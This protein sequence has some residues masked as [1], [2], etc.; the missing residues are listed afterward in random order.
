MISD[1]VTLIYF[2]RKSLH[3]W[4]T[5][6][7]CTAYYCLFPIWRHS[8]GPSVTPCRVAD[9]RD[10]ISKLPWI[11][12]VHR[13]AGNL[14]WNHWKFGFFK[15]MRFRLGSWFSWEM[16][17]PDLPLFNLWHRF[18]G[19]RW[20]WERRQQ[21]QRNK[22]LQSF[23][24]RSGASKDLHITW[25]YPNPKGIIAFPIP[26]VWSQQRCA[27]DLFLTCFWPWPSHTIPAW[28]R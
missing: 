21:S 4:V 13:C 6:L 1:T 17:L 22:R 9:Q 10:Q 7:Y 24:V 14:H 28:S 27:F 19:A 16:C 25:A 2:H 11:H 12:D 8:R 26:D 23:L 5:I 18:E 3:S 20:P 15:A